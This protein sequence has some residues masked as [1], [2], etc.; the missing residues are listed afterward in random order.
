MY[1][2]VRRKLSLIIF[3]IYQEQKKRQVELEQQC[4]RI[5]NQLCFEN[6]NDTESKFS[7]HIFIKCSFSY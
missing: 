3:R 4:D 1:V 2:D 7:N 5:R 6:E